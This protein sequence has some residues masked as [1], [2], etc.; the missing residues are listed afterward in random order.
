MSSV[1]TSTKTGRADSSTVRTRK[2]AFDIFKESSQTYYYSS[3]FF[4]SDVQE[5][6]AKLY[7]FVRMADNFVDAIPQDAEGF[8]KFRNEYEK[9]GHARPVIRAFWRLEQ[10]YNFDSSWTTAFLDSMEQ[11]LSKRKY[12]SMQDVKLYMYGSAEM[13]GRMLC[14][15]F[16][17]PDNAHESG[18][19]LARGMQYINFLRDIPEDLTYERTYIPQQILQKHNIQSLKQEHVHNSPRAFETMMKQELARGQEWL[20]KG[21][22]GFRF[23]PTRTEIAVA[24]ATDMYN[25]TA[26]Q[27][28]ENPFIIYENKVKPSIYQVIYAGIKRSVYDQTTANI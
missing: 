13:I 9:K 20:R 27:I 16:D 15:I 14:E 8:Q 2:K 17:L 7:A 24:T 19:I 10:K 1:D 21:S 12:E 25:W 5:A 11:D 26:N 4:E 6:V 22:E 23:L 18:Q 28:R 3:W